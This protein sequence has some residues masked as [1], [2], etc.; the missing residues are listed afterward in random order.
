MMLY[1]YVKEKYNVE[2]YAPGIQ[3][4]DSELLPGETE[5]PTMFPEKV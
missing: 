5:E 3:K 4:P 2:P 1:E